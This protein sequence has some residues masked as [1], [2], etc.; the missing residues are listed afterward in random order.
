MQSGNANFTGPMIF[1][2]GLTVNCYFEF[3]SRTKQN[4]TRSR[5]LYLFTIKNVL[6]SPRIAFNFQNN[7]IVLIYSKLHFA[8]ATL[9]PIT[10]MYLKHYPF[11]IFFSCE[12][13]KFSEEKERQCKRK[14]SKGRRN[15]KGLESTAGISTLY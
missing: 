6:N 2:F 15:W 9:G 1:R 5:I 12:F 14:R 8:I 4:R 13:H 11:D 3:L 7:L 10:I